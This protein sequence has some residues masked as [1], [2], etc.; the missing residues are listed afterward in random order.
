MWR[1]QRYVSEYFMR[2]ETGSSRLTSQ[3]QFNPDLRTLMLEQ[4]ARCT[5]VLTRVV[6]KCNG[7]KA[8]SMLSQMNSTERTR[9]ERSRGAQKLDATGPAPLFLPL[10]RALTRLRVEYELHGVD[11]YAYLDE[12]HCHGGRHFIS[13]GGSGARHRVTVDREGYTPQLGHNGSLDPERD[14]WPR[15]IRLVLVAGVAVRI[16]GE[17]RMK[18]VGLPVGDDEIVT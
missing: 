2:L 11:A 12:H 4:E 7:K 5:P 14:M 16:S 13:N 3:T 17:G 15:R 1:I 18:M 9:L 6:A 8:A 10:W